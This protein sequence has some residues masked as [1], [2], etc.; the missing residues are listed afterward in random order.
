M[1]LTDKVRSGNRL[2]HNT[3]KKTASSIKAKMPEVVGTSIEWDFMSNDA[4]VRL[5]NGGSLKTK[6][7]SGVAW[8]GKGG[9]G[10]SAYIGA[11]MKWAKSKYPSL[12]E[13]EVKR[14]AFAVAGAAKDRG[15]TV[16]SPGWLDEIKQE[17]D[18]QIS[19]E[20]NKSIRAVVNKKLNE[21]KL[22]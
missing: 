8:S 16:K 11:L 22:K 12:S 5:N 20:L 2:P 1:A 6:G 13:R 10:Q 7:S 9:G 15:R 17:L 3:T 14:M 19:Q 4:A 21:L 18:R